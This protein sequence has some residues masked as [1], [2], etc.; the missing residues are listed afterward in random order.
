MVLCILVR[1]DP[2][3]KILRLLWILSPTRQQFLGVGGLPLVVRSGS[4][5]LKDHLHFSSD[6]ALTLL[7]LSVRSSLS[8][9]KGPSN[10]EG[11]L[12]P[13]TL[14]WSHE[15]RA[16]WYNGANIVRKELPHKYSGNSRA[17]G[18]KVWPS[19]PASAFLLHR[20]LNINVLFLKLAYFF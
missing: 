16:L 13:Y 9:L 2:L 20:K 5:D 12:L 4:P 17:W 10:L 18:L 8:P 19:L 7:S 3:L 6:H 15:S 1:F 11:H 14:N